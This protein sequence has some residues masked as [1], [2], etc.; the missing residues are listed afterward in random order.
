MTKD[1]LEHLSD[2]NIELNRD[3]ER[4]R[5]LQS[6]VAGHTSSISGLPHIGILQ[7]NIGLYLAMIDELKKVIMKRVLS[8][9]LE[10][11]K[12]NAFVND[13][14]DPLLRQIIL[15]RY[16]DRLQWRQ[17]AARIGGNNT[18]DSVRLMV[19]RYLNSLKK[20]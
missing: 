11:A 15:Y 19:N 10:Y 1:E 13:I 3:L 4:L 18:E 16:V 17:I 12:L 7:D 14:D 5:E 6:A 9:I 20:S 8:S 2:L